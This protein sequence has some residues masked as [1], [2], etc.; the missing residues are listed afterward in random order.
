MTTQ[1]DG[2]K[3]ADLIRLAMELSIE[4]AARRSAAEHILSALYEGRSGGEEKK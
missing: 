3:N 1:V 2:E 4:A